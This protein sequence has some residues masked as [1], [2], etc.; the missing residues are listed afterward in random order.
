MARFRILFLNLILLS[1]YSP[2]ITASPDQ[3]P[4][5]P[6]SHDT[7][8]VGALNDLKTA[9]DW[10]AAVLGT[11]LAAATAT[12][13][14]PDYDLSNK[15]LT[16]LVSFYFGQNA[17]SLKLQAYDDIL[18]V[19]LNWLEGVKTIDH[20]ISNTAS[21]PAGASTGE[22]WK[23]PFAQRAYDFYQ[24]AH[25]GWDTTLCGGGMVWSPWLEPYKNAIT[26]EL[27]I[28]A[29]VSMYL[30]HPYPA[31]NQTY[32]DNAIL[33]HKWLLASNMTDAAGLYTDGFHVTNLKYGGNKCDI[34]DEM[35]YTYNQGVL[36]SGLRGL[37]EAT[38]NEA[39][40]SEGIALIDNVFNSQGSYGELML[41]GILT[42]KCDPGGYCSQ[43]GQTFKG[44]FMH[45]LTLF[46]QPLVS[47]NA[48]APTF[49]SGSK[50][51]HTESC[52]K[53]KDFVQRNADAAWSTRNANGVVG[54]WWGV[55]NGWQSAT[56]M[57][58]DTRP[59]G[60]VDV[61]NGCAAGENSDV[62][63]RRQRSP[64]DGETWKRRADL[65]DRGR[66]RTVE[67]HVGG[68]AAVRALLEMM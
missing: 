21:L 18:W 67:S 31:R 68:V 24:I 17:E 54:S 42:E 63:E 32:L 39:Y 34:R 10:T 55:P 33:A 29:S 13:S 50:K 65:N 47:I 9:I 16:Q 25:E 19:V 3:V 28:S 53:Y 12:F 60:A 59:P 5:L 20:R 14:I 30:Y 23:A 8:T 7:K 45:H 62:C 26:N 38:G 35:V 2:T 49:S 37:A 41:Y 66:G 27:Y 4:L 51:R 40:L 48:S 6:K 52:Y 46:C 56:T 64:V 57:N 22:E 61:A 36:L 1:S 44:I 15:Y 11:V 43:N 58:R